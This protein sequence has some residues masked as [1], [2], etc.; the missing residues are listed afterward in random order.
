[1]IAAAVQYIVEPESV[2]QMHSGEL[3]RISVCITQPLSNAEV[4][5]APHDPNKAGKAVSQTMVEF[6]LLSVRGSN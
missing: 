1:M 4:A 3:K 5:A 6:M 2:I